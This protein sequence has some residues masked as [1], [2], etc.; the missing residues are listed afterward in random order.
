MN[1]CATILENIGATDIVVHENGK[2]DATLDG[3]RFFGLS[4]ENID[5][6]ES[7]DVDPSTETVSV[8]FTPY[9]GVI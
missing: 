1:S 5:M 7:Q 6:G 9:K 8:K 3:T 2:V 4:L